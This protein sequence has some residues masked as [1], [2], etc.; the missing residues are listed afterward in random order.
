VTVT[1]L[2]YGS[3]DDQV[4]DLHVPQGSSPSGGWPT[5]VLLHGGFWREQ[6]RRDLTDPL[7]VDLASRGVAA[8]NV[9]YRRV[10]GDGGWP[11]T[12]EDVAAAVD[13]LAELAGPHHLD[14]TRTTVVGH[15]AGGHLALWVAGR[16]LLPADAPGAGPRLQPSAVVGLAPVADLRA[17]DDARLSDMAVREFLGGA[18]HEHPRRWDQADPVRLVGHG[19]PVLLVHG[20]DD[21]SVPMEQSE[22]YAAAA[23]RVGDEVTLAVLPAA[24]MDVIDPTH[25][26]WAKTVSWLQGR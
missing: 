12:V 13:H 20:S 19:I 14:V 5:V 9:E 21:E 2:R 7:A 22:A 8:W 3:H 17:V 4:A 24:H 15:S 1:T 26:A 25:A 23:T 16:R 6:Y 10:R 18:P 11:A